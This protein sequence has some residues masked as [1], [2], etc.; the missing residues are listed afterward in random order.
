MKRAIR[1]FA[2]CALSVALL[3]MS[4]FAAKGCGPGPLVIQ[5]NQGMLVQSFGATTNA[6]LLPT[7][8]FAISSGTSGCSSSGIVNRDAEQ[9]FF[10]TVNL[11]NLS[12]EMAQGEGPYLESLATL[13]GCDGVLRGE[14]SRLARENYAVLFGDGAVQPVGMLSRLKTEMQRNPRLAAGCSRIT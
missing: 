4:V 2:L 13:L 1:I 5:G 8:T 12:E 7:Q 10:V 11:Q 14:F 9:R 3:E 6:I